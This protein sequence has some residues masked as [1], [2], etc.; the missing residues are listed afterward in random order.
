MRAASTLVLVLVWLSSEVAI[1]R[2]C[3]GPP[4]MILGGPSPDGRFLSCLDPETGDLSLLDLASG[5]RRRLTHK[6]S[7]QSA[8]FA[9][10]SVVS[11]DS[12]RVAYAWFNQEKFYEL[13]VVAVDGS[14]S[15][16]LYR[17][18]EAGFVQPSAWS[19]DGKEILT[20][21]FRKDSISQ[22]ALVSTTDG[23]V[24]VLKSLNWVYPKKMDFSPDGR[25]IVYDSFGRNDARASATSL[26]SRPM[27]AAK[28]RWWSTRQ[29]IWFPSGRPTAEESFSPAIA[30]ARWTF[31]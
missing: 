15:R 10:F 24:R 2:V 28:S 16:I 26:C 21:F 11:P 30:P 14:D 1:R 8:E 23:S 27:E 19:P 13:R 20:L 17:N 6:T 5:Q 12:R 25:F 31:G 4:G 18:E 29:T 3:E 22:I 9:Y 7:P